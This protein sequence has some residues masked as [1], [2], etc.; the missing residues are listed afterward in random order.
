MGEVAQ[1]RRR[2]GDSAEVDWRNAGESKD[3]DVEGSH[4]L[5]LED[6]G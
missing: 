6:R 5:M 3:T 4:G 1:K 2:W